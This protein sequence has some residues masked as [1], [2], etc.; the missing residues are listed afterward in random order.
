L[1]GLVL[2]RAVI[3]SLL[4]LGSAAII[5][6]GVVGAIALRESTRRDAL[7]LVRSLTHRFVGFTPRANA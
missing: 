5:G 7:T 1:E 3:A 4:V 2:D 6:L